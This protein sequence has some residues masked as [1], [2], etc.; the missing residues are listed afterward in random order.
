MTTALQGINARAT[1]NVAEV[2]GMVQQ[3]DALADQL[4]ALQAAAA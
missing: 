1:T 3:N 2:G 4:C